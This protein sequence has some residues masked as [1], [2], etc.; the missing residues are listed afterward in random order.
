KVEGLT[1]REVTPVGGVPALTNGFAVSVADA[2]D[3]LDVL[4]GYEILVAGRENINYNVK[5]VTDQTAEDVQVT[6]KALII[7]TGSYADTIGKTGGSLN[8]AGDY[9]VNGA[10]VD[11]AA[12]FE[13]DGMRMYGEPNQVMGFVLEMLID[14]DSVADVNALLDWL[15]E[16]DID[17]HHLIDEDANR[18]Y[19][20]TGPTDNW[21]NEGGRAEYYFISTEMKFRNYT[22]NVILGTQNIYQRPVTLS[23]SDDDVSAYYDIS[24]ADLI[25]TLESV[26]VVGKY[27]GI[28]GLAELLNH[29]IK[30]LDLQFTFTKDD[31]ST[32][33]GTEVYVGTLRVTVDRKSTRLNS[34]HVS[35]SYA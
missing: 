14:G 33:N 28:G 20:A 5:Y 9:P 23:L 10:I 30:D 15:V 27:N 19:S 7:K 21:I 11:P 16:F 22:E 26:L 18:Y 3:N 31:G 2:Y 6:E 35:I 24:R 12:L 17:D 34:S 8:P 4:D 1:Y 32:W 25:S 29:T 13:T